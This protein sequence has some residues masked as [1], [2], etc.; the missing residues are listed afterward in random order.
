M[1]EVIRGRMDKKT[2]A[3]HIAAWTD[4]NVEPIARERFR[5]AAEADLLGLHEGNFAHYRV[6]PS[7]FAAWQE[8]WNR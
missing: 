6:R 7:E 3:A 2:A 5:D 4:A 1:A 8:A